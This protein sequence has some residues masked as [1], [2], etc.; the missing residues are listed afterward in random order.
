MKIAYLKMAALI[1]VVSFFLLPTFTK[2]E[3][4]GNNVF[5]VSLNGMFV[6]TVSDEAKADRLLWEARKNIAGQKEE[7]FFA[8]ELSLSGRTYFERFTDDEKIIDSETVLVVDHVVARQ[9]AFI[10]KVNQL[11]VNVSNI[12]E[13]N[14]A[15]QAALDKYQDSQEYMFV[16][17]HG[18]RN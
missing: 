16:I 11:M 4:S 13:V 18:K 12:S 17:G 2:V 14:A 7:L 9:P 1:F 15:L 6:G 10:I 8:T 3:S 5:D